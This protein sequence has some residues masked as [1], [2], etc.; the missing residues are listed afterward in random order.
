MLRMLILYYVYG[1]YVLDY[2]SQAPKSEVSVLG[3]QMAIFFLC[4]CMVFLLWV[5]VS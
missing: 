4:S 3:L 1:T 5:Y 2:I